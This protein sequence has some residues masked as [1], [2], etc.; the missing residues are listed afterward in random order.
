MNNDC[1]FFFTI[2]KRVR[3]NTVGKQ[4]KH[5]LGRSRSKGTSGKGSP[6]F[7]DGISKRN[8]CVP[9]LQSCLCYQFQAFTAV[10]WLMA[11]ICQTESKA[12]EK[13]FTQSGMT[14]SYIN[15]YK[16]V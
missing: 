6:V 7:L 4:M 5:D 1:F 14:D 12:L 16:L 10:F 8:V 3:E 2:Y 11:L 13:P 15:Y 9:F